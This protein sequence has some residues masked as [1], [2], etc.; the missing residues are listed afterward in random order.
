MSRFLLRRTRQQPTAVP[1][2]TTR[3]EEFAKAVAAFRQATGK[4]EARVIPCRCAVTSELFAIVFE[5]MSPAHRF[6]IARIE[7]ES[8][9]GDGPNG[10]ARLFARTPQQDAYDAGEFDWA[11]CACPHCGNRTGVVCCNE[12]GETVCAGRVRPL[13]DGSRAFACHDRC[14]ATGTLVPATHVHGAVA[15]KTALLQL[16]GPRTVKA[17]PRSARSFAPRQK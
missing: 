16:T 14:G 11:G 1:T 6:Q 10:L 5:R 3:G 12:C 15:G 8:A 2:A 17:L 9:A 7:A 13:P 4:A